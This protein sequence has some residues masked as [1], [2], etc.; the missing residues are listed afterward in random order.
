MRFEGRCDFHQRQSTRIYNSPSFPKVSA[1][2]AMAVAAA[3]YTKW[4]DAAISFKR[5]LVL[6]STTQEALK[7]AAPGGLVL[8][9][10]GL[11]LHSRKHLCQNELF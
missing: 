4:P 11:C 8:A 6:V 1:V 2:A 7:A 5:N 3:A 9:L 10:A